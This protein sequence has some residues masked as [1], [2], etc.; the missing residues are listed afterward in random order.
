MVHS[1]G[2]FSGVDVVGVDAGS[3]DL[4]SGPPVNMFR[5]LELV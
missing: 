4:G 2:R 1:C 5:M 3:I